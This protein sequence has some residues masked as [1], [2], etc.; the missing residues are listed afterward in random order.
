MIITICAI[1]S[2]L[3]AV[4]GLVWRLWRKGANHEAVEADVDSKLYNDLDDYDR[5]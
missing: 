2:A 1:I 4:G 5:M 3:A